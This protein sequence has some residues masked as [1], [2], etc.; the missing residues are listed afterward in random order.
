M[1]AQLVLSFM[2]AGTAPTSL[3][4]DLVTPQGEAVAF[5]LRA[6]GDGASAA[7]LTPA[8]STVWPSTR[9]AGGG[10]LAMKKS[11]LDAAFSF[12]TG[13]KGVAVEIKGDRAALSLKGTRH[14]LPVAFGFCLPAPDMA[15][16]DS[17]VAV[18][19]GI[20]ISAFDAASWGTSCGLVT[21]SGRRAKIDYTLLDQ[22]KRSRI[23]SAD[24]Q[25][26]SRSD[27]VVDRIAG[28]GRTRFG[29]QGDVSG[30]EEL[31]L[32]QGWTR[33]VQLLDF[34]RIGVPPAPQERAVAICGHGSI[35]A[36]PAR[37]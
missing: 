30:V 31:V 21:R 27:I 34:D 11:G 17:L 19:A 10:S 12:G 13:K 8:A 3:T 16:G 1:I 15:A 22:G 37:Q 36:R 2:A 26:F 32:D 5:S 25:L 14:D 20:D 28:V 33:G 29:N 24:P 7:F 23:R 18:K 4:C 6:S 9:L 35:T